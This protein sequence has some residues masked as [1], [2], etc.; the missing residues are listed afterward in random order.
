MLLCHRGCELEAT[1]TNYLGKP[2]CF[3]AAPKCPVVK[4][5]AGERSGASRK[6]KPLSDNRREKLRN[7]L[8]DRE[9]KPET[10]KKIEE[11]N[12]EHWKTNTRTPWN[13]GKKGVQV[14]WNKGKTGYSMPPRRTISE[15]DYKD[16]QR[17]KRAVYTASRKVY[18]QN[19]DTLNPTRVL[20]GRS[21]ILDAHQI[22]HKVPISIG[23]NLKIPVAV[24]SIVENLQLMHWK[25]NLNKSNKEVSNEILTFLL[26]KSK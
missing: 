22:D 20:L 5:K 15:E 11:S 19:I 12:K 2:C 23:Y 16:Y 18:Q 3:K 6:G 26:E 14:P 13:K 24:M 7:A 9:C 10:R 1:F 8:L 21:G 4:K 17:Y 25:D